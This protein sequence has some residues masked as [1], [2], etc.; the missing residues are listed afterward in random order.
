MIEAPPAYKLSTSGEKRKIKS[1]YLLIVKI[2]TVI[3]VGECKNSFPRSTSLRYAVLQP[4][5]FPVNQMAVP[6][7]RR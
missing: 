3:K 2:H 4:S 6:G 1:P 5:G 7:G